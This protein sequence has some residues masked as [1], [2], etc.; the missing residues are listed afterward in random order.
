M[1]R[2]LCTWIY[3]ETARRMGV[4]S[5]LLY[6]CS[7]WPRPHGGRGRG[8]RGHHVTTSAHVRLVALPSLGPG[9][10]GPLRSEPTG[11]Q[12]DHWC[13]LISRPKWGADI[14]VQT[15]ANLQRGNTRK[16]RR[17]PSLPSTI[18]RQAGL[19]IVGNK[20]EIRAEVEPRVYKPHII[21]F[22]NSP[23]ATVVS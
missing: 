21:T 16:Q 11:E 18:A 12:R 9:R 14:S 15:Q 7:I 6:L 5:A 1:G 2:N 23:V 20:E 10:S 4:N 17:H 8:C 3:K 13:C 22:T 19:S